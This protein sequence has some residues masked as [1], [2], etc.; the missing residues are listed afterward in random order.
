MK[1]D[2]FVRHLGG[3]GDNLPKYTYNLSIYVYV[4]MC[5]HMPSL[6]L[7]LSQSYLSLGHLFWSHNKAAQ[8][9]GGDCS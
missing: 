2:G 9:I 8:I 3:R 1:N 7:L 4:Y 5:V 6:V